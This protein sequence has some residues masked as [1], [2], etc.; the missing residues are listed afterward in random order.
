[1][2]DALRI[3]QTVD[4]RRVVEAAIDW[5]SNE[6]VYGLSDSSRAS[7]FVETP[8]K[9][10]IM[11]NA[12]RTACAPVSS[13]PISTTMRWH[14][15]SAGEFPGQ[16]GMYL[17]L[18]SALQDGSRYTDIVC[19]QLT[20]RTLTGDITNPNVRFQLNTTSSSPFTPPQISHSR[21]SLFPIQFKTVSNGGISYFSSVV[22]H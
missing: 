11:R 17:P 7:E 18:R 19:Q 10:F 8:W 12:R 14:S 9:W 4:M 5:Q 6:F 2:D 3:L 16:Q 13:R 20:S 21:S 22:S 1:M 15:I